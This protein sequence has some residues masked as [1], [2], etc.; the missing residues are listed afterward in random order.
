MERRG[1]RKV[2]K[3]F[4]LCG[5]LLCGLLL[6]G[7]G[8]PGAGQTAESIPRAVEPV[9]ES[10]AYRE[11]ES[12]TDS[13][14]A[15]E[16][17]PELLQDEGLRTIV[18]NAARIAWEDEE[19]AL[20]Q[21]L[22]QCEYLLL[23]RESVHSLEG[24][25]AALPNLQSLTINYGAWD[26]SEILDFAPIAELSCLSQLYIQYPAG[27]E[28]DFSFLAKMDTVTEL[29]LVNCD[30][31]DASFLTEMSQLECLSLYQTPVEDLAVLENMTGLVELA[32]YG[33]GE[34]K[35]METIGKLLNMQDLGLQDCGI[36]DISF[37][38]GLTR[39]RS[40]NLNYNAVTDLTP[41]A[42]LTEL[43][44]LGL[45]GNAVSDISPIAGLENLFDLALDGNHISDISAL[46][47]LPHLNQVGLSDNQIQDFSPLK[48][49]R[50]LLYVSVSGNP[51]TDLEPVLT[52]PFLYFANRSAPDSEEHLKTVADWMERYRPDMEEYECSD[53]M[54]ADLNGDGLPDAVFVVDGEF[55][56]D[57]IYAY[58]NEHRLF[59][60][61]RNKDGS[62]R[63][64]EHDIHI[65]D[66]ISGGMRGD[67]YR[68][69]WMGGGYVLVKEEHG[70][71]DG[72]TATEV[73]RY[74]QGRLER[75][76]TVAVDDYIGAEGYDVR[77]YNEEEG[78][79]VKYAIAMDGYRMVRVDLADNEYP[80]TH[81]AFPNLEIYSSSYY[82]Y[83]D[84]LP[85]CM[86]GAAALEC[87]RDS[88][89]G[90]WVQEMLPY[91]PWQKENY[92]LLM[93][94][95]LPDY[96]Y[97]TEDAYFYY[98]ELKYSGGEY[99]HVI[100]YVWDGKYHQDYRIKDSTG[101]LEEK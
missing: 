78:T 12:S 86:D 55:M 4:L 81:G 88:E 5:T 17:L 93:G 46:K 47:N 23:Q 42:E 71:G 40:V 44:R 32:L 29:F 99:F 8:L 100:R 101:E 28:L 9:A 18:R 21:K 76:W 51:C 38:G 67:P 27:R 69:M 7:C 36:E 30:L 11:T 33:N 59:I 24:L 90:D 20:W 70:S 73:Y 84:K 37:L 48:D 89:E 66:F 96:Y 39:L 83:P 14:T 80:A 56:E 98:R 58:D 50:E 87:F 92:E 31:K 2:N 6:T 41:L 35:N 61:L 72:T 64:V 15:R 79:W 91:A 95:E 68:G 94:V 62:W 63:E 54:E 60:L 53:Y 45:V 52:V 10:D 1:N 74:R 82:I 85:T 97:V 57:D 34:A 75:V 26:D 16:I 3:G 19:E 77:V 43:E 49:K 13:R 22:E 65:G 25:G